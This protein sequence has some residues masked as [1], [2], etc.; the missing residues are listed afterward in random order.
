METQR[1]ST[2]QQEDYLKKLDERGEFGLYKFI[3]GSVL[4]NWSRGIGV[5]NPD[6]ELLDLSES[7]FS[8]SRATGDKKSFLLGKVLRKV[9]HKLY[10]V[11]RAVD[12]K[13]VS[14]DRFIR[15]V[16]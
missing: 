9:S 2:K 16:G 4:N 7:F 3:L 6:V 13:K 15:S 8:L 10:R 12:K 5:K 1:I 14:N 11:T